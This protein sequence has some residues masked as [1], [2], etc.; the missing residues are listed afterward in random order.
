MEGYTDKI[1]DETV[2]EGDPE[3]LM[4]FLTEKQ[5]PVLK[6]EPLM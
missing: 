3:A 6:L 5:H 2:T 4:A 1:A